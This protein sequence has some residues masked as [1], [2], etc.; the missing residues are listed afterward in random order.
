M[1]ITVTLLEMA[2]YPASKPLWPGE[3]VALCAA[4]EKKLAEKSGPDEQPDRSVFGPI[5][6]WLDEHDE[7]EYARGWRYLAK[8]PDTGIRK[9]SYGWYIADHL[10]YRPDLEASGDTSTL[11]GA[12]AGLAL[13]IATIRSEL[14]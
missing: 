3:F 6:D 2:K 4:A 9:E 8:R 1:P 13:K 14:E 12:V 10:P 5:A 7:P 11:A